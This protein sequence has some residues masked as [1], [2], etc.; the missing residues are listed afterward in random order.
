MQVIPGYVE[1]PVRGWHHPV[2]AAVVD[3]ASAATP[4]GRD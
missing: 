1:E 2:M 3:Q 4:H